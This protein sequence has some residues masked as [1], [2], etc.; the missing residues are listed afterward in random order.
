ME[1]VVQRIS[2]SGVCRTVPGEDAPTG[3]SIGYCNRR[4]KSSREA[5]AAE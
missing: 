1:N 4:L 2:P 3:I 5:D